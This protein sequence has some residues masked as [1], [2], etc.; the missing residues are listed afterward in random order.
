M[1]DLIFGVVWTTSLCRCVKIS[2]SILW[3][4]YIVRDFYLRTAD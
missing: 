3:L 1:Q 2:M 4:L